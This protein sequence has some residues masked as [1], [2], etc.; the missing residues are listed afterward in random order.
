[1][2]RQQEWAQRAFTSV[3]SQVKASTEKKYA[4][5]CM[6][7][8]S[9]LLQ[10]GLVQT[11]A[12]LRSRG[13]DAAKLYL[14]DLAKALGDQSGDKLDERARAAALGEYLRLSRDAVAVASWFRRFAQVELEAEGE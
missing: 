7:A 13:D 3:K 9:M 8:P 2:S 11:T 14:N 10:S 1:M 6:K 4:T 12:F 5:Y